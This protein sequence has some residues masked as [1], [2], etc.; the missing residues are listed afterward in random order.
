MDQNGP[1]ERKVK[2]R[3]IM[4][5]EL[6]T[7]QYVLFGLIKKTKRQKFFPVMP[8]RLEICVPG[9]ELL[10][11]DL[12]PNLKWIRT[13]CRPVPYR[14][15]FISGTGSVVHCL[16]NDFSYC[17]RMA[18]WGLHQNSPKFQQKVACGF[19]RFILQ[20]ETPDQFFFSQFG[21]DF[22][23][24]TQHR[25]HL[26]PHRIHCVGGCWDWIQRWNS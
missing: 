18:L 20:I 2:I 16:K 11:P 8:W 1:Q 10:F 25:L 5:G 24:F 3:N 22:L 21:L 7:V 9:P 15:F 17:K 6:Y 12:D 4:F 19:V 13:V 23:S 14:I 26:P